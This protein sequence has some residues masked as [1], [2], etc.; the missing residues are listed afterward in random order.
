MSGV[1]K[2]GVWEG[3]E[4][5]AHSLVQEYQD[6]PLSV[7]FEA[8]SYPSVCC[9]SHCRRRSVSIS[10]FASINLSIISEIL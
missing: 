4:R 8:Q 7:L 5:H 3:S 9:S 1:G 10:G 2:E 6:R